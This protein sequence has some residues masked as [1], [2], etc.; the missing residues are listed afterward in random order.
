[1]FFSC[2]PP[3]DTFQNGNS[4]QLPFEGASEFVLPQ[5]WCFFLRIRSSLST[6]RGFFW[7]KFGASMAL[8][9]RFLPLFSELSFP[10]AFCVLC[11][12]SCGWGCVLASRETAPRDPTTILRASPNSPYALG[13]P[14]VPSFSTPVNVVPHEWIAGSRTT[15]YVATL[16]H[17]FFFKPF[18]FP[19]FAR[20]SE[21]SV[22][23]PF[24]RSHHGLP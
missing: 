19:G 13:C 21:P 18:F 16:P 14:A 4:R 24:H 15:Q 3:L 6:S 22:Q 9:S 1:V 20:A 12:R 8:F 17:F 5:S 23:A 7:A 2:P 11:T 10:S